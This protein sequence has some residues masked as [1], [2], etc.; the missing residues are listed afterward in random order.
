MVIPAVRGDLAFVGLLF[1]C[2]HAEERRL[3][4]AVGTNEA[5]FLTLV[6]GGRCL[7][8][9][10]LVAVLLADAVETNHA[11]RVV[12]VPGRRA[13]TSC[14]QRAKDVRPG[15]YGHG[16]F[17]CTDA[18]D[19]TAGSSARTGQQSRPLSPVHDLR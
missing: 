18:S 5:D 8:E 10:D 6:E 4:G 11:V 7:D 15:A 2:D 17:G 14:G 16:S 19:R 9:K 13:L 12:P 3:A 1:A